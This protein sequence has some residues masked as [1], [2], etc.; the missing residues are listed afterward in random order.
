MLTAPNI[1]V[2]VWGPPSSLDA[3]HAQW[4][5]D[6]ASMYMG[7]LGNI[8]FMTPFRQYVGGGPNGG[9][10]YAFASS[11]SYNYI[12]PA[13]PG[14]ITT[15][16][17]IELQRQIGLGNLLP[18]SAYPNSQAVYVVI[19]P[20]TIRLGGSCSAWWGV[21]GWTNILG[22]GIIAI[23]FCNG[24][25]PDGSPGGVMSEAQAQSVAVHEIMETM[26]DPYV[27]YGGLWVRS[28]PLAGNEIGDLCQWQGQA[29]LRFISD[30]RPPTRCRSFLA[31][32]LT[33][34]G[35]HSV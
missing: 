11:V 34:Q 24:N 2:V 7:L 27:G 1:Q 9:P 31:M 5:K 22:A 21:H 8:D 19:L 29:T 16:T 4:V 32:T 10:I 18:A 35:L 30:R 26:T 17:A 33:M 28:G 6:I 12:T 20:P 23:P 25:Y 15:D 13:T 14:N 3:T